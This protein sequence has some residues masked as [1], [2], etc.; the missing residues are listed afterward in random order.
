MAN[1]SPKSSAKSAAMLNYSAPALER[2]F[3]VLNL[4]AEHPSGLT[5]SEIAAGLGL[6]IS[7]IFR[8]IMVMERLQWLKR[9]RGDRLRV[10]TQML[11]LAFK[12]T[13]VDD[14]VQA[15]TPH[16]RALSN[17]IEQSCHLVVRNG[18]SGLVVSRQQT[19]GPTVF[20]VRIGANIALNT[21]CSGHVL[22]AFEAVNEGS[23]DEPAP[24]GEMLSATIQKV[25][26]RGYEMMKS[27][28]TEGVTDMSC[29]IFGGTGRALGALTVPFLKLIDGSQTIGRDQA[30]TCLQETAAQ[31]SEEL[32]GVR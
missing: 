24:L 7:E 2:G 26:A 4:L 10:S 29:P 28:R 27:A 3:S 13:P 30:R 21:T 22:L 14:L 8:I 23:A 5:V 12:A 6:S 1:E 19:P 16:M 32:S 25:R 9:D 15:A 18:A 20:M 17:R 11:D 31:I